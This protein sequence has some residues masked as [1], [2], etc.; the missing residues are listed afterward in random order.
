MIWLFTG[1]LAWYAIGFAGSLWATHLYR[2]VDMEDVLVF[3]LVGILGPLT[4]IMVISASPAMRS[5][6]VIRRRK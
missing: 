6:V 5:R 3:L 1:L 2:N 4:M